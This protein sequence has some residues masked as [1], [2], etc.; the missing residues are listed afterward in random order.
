[1]LRAAYPLCKVKRG[2]YSSACIDHS[3]YQTLNNLIV[4]QKE[5][6]EGRVLDKRFLGPSQMQRTQ[7]NFLHY[8]WTLWRALSAI[9]AKTNIIKGCAT[10]QQ[11]SYHSANQ[12]NP[13]SVE[14]ITLAKWLLEFLGIKV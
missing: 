9:C 13:Q 4:L 2:T 14:G 3:F 11:R 5:L 10:S 8:E 6:A 1:M 12:T 7:I